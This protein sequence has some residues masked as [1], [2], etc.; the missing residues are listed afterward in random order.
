[1]SQPK[2]LL[3]D[4]C[5]WACSRGADS[6][7]VEFEDGRLFVYAR[8][9]DT[10][11]SIADFEGSQSDARELLDNLYSAARRPAGAMIAGHPSKLHVSIGESFGEDTFTVTIK[12]AASGAAP[13][14]WIF[15]PKQGQYLAY[16]HQYS[17][18]HRRAPSE[19]DLQ[20][21]FRVTPPSVHNM[22][23]ALERNGLIERTP[24]QARS[25]RVLVPPE[26]LPPLE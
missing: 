20:G 19:A 17:K 9:G 22:I 11:V 16:I 14:K 2:T 8:S 25:I 23:I 18:I 4:I 1:M 26:R 13:G 7:E 15:T 24:G 6:L 12:P 21:Y 3:A 5:D 10:S